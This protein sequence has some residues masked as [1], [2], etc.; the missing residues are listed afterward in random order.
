MQ[1]NTILIVDDDPL[2][3]TSMKSALSSQGY[4]VTTA[5]NGT[6]A[7]KL[8][9]AA[10]HDLV[11]T[12]LVMGK[13]DGLGV[14]KKAKE[15]HPDTM[16]IILTGFGEL[17]SAIAALRLGADDYLLKPCDMDEL[18]FRVA[19]AFRKLELIRKVKLY[20]D[21]L[22]VCCVCSK[23]RDDDA[24][25]PGTGQWVSLSEYM[26]DKAHV[27]VSHTYCPECARKLESEI[28]TGTRDD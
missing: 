13:L 16:V 10:R 1:P 3:L 19:V 8:M 22:P 9:R 17:S 20:E 12:D 11:I 6:A 15:L 24:R 27:D 2:I 4:A 7:V 21:I 28:D 25:E 5:G 23:I 26:K 18:F 14:L